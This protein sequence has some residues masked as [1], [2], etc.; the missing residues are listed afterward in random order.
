MFGPLDSIF[1]IFTPDPLVG[2][3]P[4]NRGKVAWWLTVPGWDGG[5]Q[6]YDLIGSNHGTL[7]NMGVGW[8]W[9]N[10][11]RPGGW[12][13]VQFD[14]TSS[15]VG[16]PLAAPT[17]STGTIAWWQDPAGTPT[18]G[19]DRFAWGVGDA[20][21]ANQ[22]SAEKWTDNQW[23]I[24]WIAGGVDQRAVFAAT[25]AN[26]RRGRYHLTWQAGGPSQVYLDG[27]L[28]GQ[29]AGNTSA[30]ATVTG[31]TFRLGAASDLVSFWSGGLDN[32]AIWNRTL[33]AAEI[34]EECRSDV[35]GYPGVLR[36][37]APRVVRPAPVT[38]FP[39]INMGDPMVGAP[40]GGSIL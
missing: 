8:G 26:F 10:T 27:T 11:A 2:E 7:A 19:V 17:F 13:Q 37:F 20:T 38:L 23:Y 6:W 32:I 4:L 39:F 31:A 36:R 34:A 12:G 1:P 16:T 21:F 29:N 25:D 22:V 35:L 24:G 18:D 5:R 9:R 3:H 40:F 15:Y 14:G 28:I 33:T 30:P